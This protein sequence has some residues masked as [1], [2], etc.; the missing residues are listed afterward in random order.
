V[1]LGLLDISIILFYLVTVLAIGFYVSRRA[2]ENLDSYFLGGNKIPFYL[3]GIANATGMFDIAGTM[4]LVTLFVLY[5][6][7]SAFIP[8]LWPIF[9]QVFLMVFLAVWLRRAGVMT[10]AEWI[11]VRFGASRGAVLSHLS[12]VL[13]AMVGVI[14][15]LAYA[16]QGVGKFAAVFFPWDV[17]PHVYALILMAITT[18]YVIAGGM[19]SVVIT[20]LVQYVLLT[21]SAVCIGY[22]AFSRTSAADIAASVPAGWDSLS[23]GWKLN[24]D[25]SGLLSSGNAQLA[26]DGYEFFTVFIILVLFKGILASLA[27]PAPNYDMQRILAT[28]SPREAA[29]MSWFTSV[30]LF[31]PRYLLVAAIGV[32]G[33]VFF[34][35]SLNQ[36][37][38]NV[39]FEQIMPYVL[40]NFIPSGLLGV[41]LAGLLAAFMSTFDCTVN[42]GASYLVKDVYQRYINPQ[43]SDSRL[44]VLS[45]IASI[46]IVAIGIAF[47]LMTKSI[48]QVVQWIMSGLYGGY[49][50]PN[51][52]KWYWWRFNGYGYFAG[53]VCGIGS[54]LL[55]PILM[56]GVSALNGF[57]F[58]LLFSGVASIVVSLMTK[59]EP[60]EVL[61]EFYRRTRP[62]GFWKP[63]IDSMHAQQ[64]PIEQNTAFLRDSLNIAVGIVWQM[65]LCLLPFYFVIRKWDGFRWT[66]A[67]LVATSVFLK[68]NWYNKLSAECPQK[69]EPASRPLVA[70]AAQ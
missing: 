57:P 62:W 5:G 18:V 28:R 38:D 40:A 49:V 61:Q 54:A 33:L 11:G 29:L 51:V 6:I 68:F 15:F 41:V 39:D 2:G 23:F 8:W 47:G 32:M 17:H 53:M 20:D 31:I 55:F 63:V 44:V 43:A 24:L 1:S 22:I 66:A 27:G 13:F 19:Y 60:M 4:W 21:I 12:V 16:F 36:M 46:L 37:G 10:G 35:G 7:K 56:P 52:L 69:I 3:L 42:A 50:A 9:N 48:D 64:E 25:W 30:S 34:K 70:E 65:C 67:V 59:P 58:L 26:K 45:Y 14:A